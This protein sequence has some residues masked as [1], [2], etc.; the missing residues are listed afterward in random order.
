MVNNA[1]AGSIVN[2][3]TINKTS[4]GTTFM[5]TA[6]FTNSNG[7]IIKGLGTYNLNSG[8]FINTGIIS[9]GSS[10]GIL[11]I[12]G[13]EPLTSNSTLEI[14]ILDN[15][16]P[17]TGHDQL[18][19]EG[20]LTL[21][22][23]LKVTETGEVPNGS[24][25]IIKLLGGVISGKFNEVILPEGYSLKEN[26]T[27][28]VLERNVV[29]STDCNGVENGL[30]KLDE[31]GICRLPDDPDFNSTCTD[32]AGIPNGD[33]FL[34]ECDVCIF[35]K[36]ITL[37]S[38]NGTFGQ[39]DDLI[40]MLVGPADEAFP[41]VLTASDFQ[42]ASNGPSA[43]IIPNY[44]SWIS[45]LPAD[46]EAKWIN[47]SG[48]N[49]TGSTVLYAIDFVIDFDFNDA[50]IDFYYAIDNFKGGDQNQG[51]Y[52]N[53]QPLS[54][55]TTGGDFLG[56]YLISRNDIA[57]LLK[58][59]TNTLYMNSTDV[60]GPSG[61][62]FSAKITVT[63]VPNE[64]CA[65]CAGI[66]NGTSL[67]GTSCVLN[68]SNGTYNENCSCIVPTIIAPESI[69][70]GSDVGTCEA[71]EID[72]GTPTVTGEDIPAD[73][74]SN[75]A[76]ES[77]SV[78]STKVI[79]TVTDGNGNTSTSEQTV[80][81]EDNEIPLISAPANV[82][83]QIAEGTDTVTDVELGIPITSDN[84]G[85]AS[86]TNDAPSSFP[87]GTTPITWV[88]TDK[89]GNT[90]TAGQIVTVSREILP[91]IL[92]PA[93]ITLD[94][95]EGACEATG[96][97]LGTPTV[98]GEDILGDG[99]SN[100]APEKF[101]L[102]STIVTW[103]VTDGNGNTAKAEQTITVLDNQK[104]IISAPSNV[105]IATDIGDCLASSVN[106]GQPEFSDN[107]SIASV[108]NNAPSTFPIGETQVTWTATDGSGNT[109]T[110]V[111]FV[112]V[113]D[114]QAP[115][116]TA[117]ADLTINTGIG[118]CVA[119]DVNLGNPV[120]FDNCTVSSI[121][122]DANDI[123]PIGETVVIWTVLDENGN[124]ATA[125]QTITVVDK[126]LP[127]ISAPGNL[128]VQVDPGSL[129]ATN[130]DLGT[131][132]FSDNCEVENITNNAPI[133]FPIGNTIVTWTVTDASLNSGTAMQTVTVIPEDSEL[134]TITP[135]A[136]V[137]VNAD[138]GVCEA[139]EVNI[140]TASFTGD[141]PEEGLTNNAPAVFPLGVTVV[142][143][144]VTD[145][146]GNIAE[147][148]QTVTVVDNQ[149]PQIS[150]PANTTIRTDIGDCAA[151]SV[152]LGQPEFSDN[153]SIASVTNNRPLTFPLGETLVIWT[154]IDGSGNSETATQLVTVEDLETPS[155]QAPANLTINT[156]AGICDATNVVLGN[157]ATGD[158]CGVASVKNDAPESFPIGQ[159][160]VTWTVTDV[161]GNSA[162]A[163]QTITVIDNELPTISA[164]GN[165]TVQ[166]DLG[167]SVA[168]NV[169]LGEPTVSDNC[170]VENFS[171]NAPESFPVGKTT[172][173][174][175]VTDASGNAATATQTVTVLEEESELPTITPPANVS[176]NTNKGI[177]EA[178]NVDIGFATFTGNIPD[179]GLTNDAPPVFLLGETVVTWT[180]TDINGNVVKATQTVTVLDKEAPS[181][182]APAD[183]LL[184]IVGEHILSTE[185]DLGS[186]T[187][188]DNCTVASVKNNAPIRFKVG[189]TVVK[190]TV[191]DESGNV[192]TAKQNVV[193]SKKACTT[194][195]K[196][197]PEI[198]LKLNSG[199]KA[200]LKPSMVDAGSTSD[201]GPVKLE[202]SKCDFTCA[203][204]GEHT[205]KLYA[206]DKNGN[207]VNTKFKVIIVDESKPKVSVDQTP[208]VWMMQ[209]GDTFVMPDFRDKVTASDNCSY[210]L[211]QFP[212]PGT[213]FKKPENC[214][215][216]FEAKDPSGNKAKTKFGFKLI[217]FK[218]KAMNKESRETDEVYDNLL[219]VPWN[220][221]FESL[222]AEGIEFEEGS[223]P[224]AIRQIAWS[225]DGYDPLRPGFYH[226]NAT[227]KNSG[228]EGRDV[229]FQVPVLVLNKPMPEDIILSNNVA[230]KKARSGEI[231]GDLQTIDPVDNIHSYSMEANA[232]YEIL[233]GALV[234]KGDGMPPLEVT[235]RVSSTDRAGQ[236]ISREIKVVREM[237]APIDALIYPNPATDN[238]N[239]HIR[240]IQ[241]SKVGIRIFDAAGRQIYD[242]NG[243]QESSFTR[244][245]DIRGYPAGLY[246]VIIQVDQHFITKRLV[247]E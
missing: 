159:T 217:V 144:T 30:S 51:L 218:C 105:S 94:T 9:P 134:P 39:S 24:Y 73:G 176:V 183:I 195:A 55:N 202:L 48:N 215:I 224:E 53:G 163:S 223:D 68:G 70:V 216:E 237:D 177:C 192:C 32:C 76:P 221:P 198:R 7:A 56:Q 64:S 116:I 175:T 34:D 92:A 194:I 190:W 62:I 16:G 154:V 97:D 236:T 141:I 247:K 102:G 222:V 178:S 219:T 122:N 156:D 114:L 124:S 238:T 4:T 104:P 196:A 181:I 138:Q 41:N 93:N 87:F 129:V 231:I 28:L 133:S 8:E 139:T 84:C 43:L 173:T 197:I 37:R 137:S 82:S 119:I 69:T 233:Q 135:P 26:L 31:C 21:S 207:K 240:M 5:Q 241:G 179:G 123:F 95:D 61:I 121:T 157:P 67:S 136:N 205:V 226:L 11:T 25:T 85:I 132:T 35:S 13:T 235:L 96:V 72:L 199:G 107:C 10:P 22:G 100:D 79:W 225:A 49:E 42:A 78:G 75:D 89:N 27:N 243:Y 148:T 180:V 2:T 166:V 162:T 228:F 146:K 91:T 90:A 109:Q 200:K 106:L 15:N 147:A 17:G 108:T 83:L 66:P 14:E 126:E 155:I 33:S 168:T 167:S 214:F 143:W 117:P 208:F 187:Y 46:E 209:S 212:A 230:S 45:F 111:Q 210:E 50:N 185:V 120:T 152:N 184:E 165:L 149:K 74:I 182:K 201:C 81:V 47:D 188:S 113:E 142:K 103:I 145:V 203:D 206:I 246:Q 242:E 36:S 164:P 71:T 229:N 172:V 18:V 88:V 40:T 3:G 191:T 44:P 186:P 58:Q 127:T 232:D 213:V 131:P 101:P 115:T 161:N 244:S 245:L 130:I 110:D 80:T 54:G 1:S 170:E 171:N 158:N 118:S 211:T 169:N 174:W 193:V 140:G 153:C 150:A 12:N 86:V 63:N 98:T 57:P 189:T 227:V 160:V 112:T 52:L 23:T 220:T 60:G 99:I 38:G 128:T 239:I 204:I 65:D 151:S 125:S 234:W 77:F 6:S 29:S 20:P 59:G 19:R